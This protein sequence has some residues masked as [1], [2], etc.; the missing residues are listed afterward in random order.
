M[1]ASL[2]PGLL[3]AAPSM[4]DPRFQ[5]SVILLA[6]AGEDGALGFVV[7]RNTPYT[8]DD[9]A[10]DIEFDMAPEI[11]GRSVYYGGPVSPERGWILFREPQ[12]QDAAPRDNVLHV[13]S[14]IHLA[15]TLEVLG[16][17]VTRSNASPFKLLL[18]YAGW[19]PAQ[20]EDEIREG[21]WIPMPL[22]PELLFDTPNDEMWASAL[23]SVGLTP[24]LFVMGKGGGT[25]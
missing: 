11:R 10:R 6:E 12:D 24:G 19:A 5:K 18:G 14:E 16:E 22:T 25:A 8:F 9:L 20:L 15:A 13:T 2:A 4:S 3:V 23:R 1:D 21:A 17:F 7:N